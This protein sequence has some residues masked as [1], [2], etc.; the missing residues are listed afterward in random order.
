MGATTITDQ[1]IKPNR[2]DQ[3]LSDKLIKPWSLL[4][5]FLTELK[6]L[7]EKIGGL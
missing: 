6:G 2:G 1:Q 5:M 4:M 7:S 3:H